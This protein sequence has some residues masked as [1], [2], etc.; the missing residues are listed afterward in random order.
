MFNALFISQINPLHF[1][2]PRFF[3]LKH[4]CTY[5][6][7]VFVYLWDSYDKNDCQTSIISLNNVNQLILAMGMCRALFGVT[8]S[9]FGGLRFRNM[10]PTYPGDLVVCWRLMG[11]HNCCGPSRKAAADDVCISVPWHDTRHKE[12][13]RALAKANSQRSESRTHT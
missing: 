9:G 13:F 10:W 4:T 3:N 8:S 5:I 1:I 2:K 7:H 12:M 6:C 11:Q